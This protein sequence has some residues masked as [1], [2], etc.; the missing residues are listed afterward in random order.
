MEPVTHPRSLSLNVLLSLFCIVALLS[1][2]GGSS[3]TLPPSNVVPSEA[4]RDAASPVAGRILEE[5][6][7]LATLRISVSNPQPRPDAR[8]RHYISLSTKGMTFVFSGPSK[9]KM[10]VSVLTKAPG[11]RK[12]SG[13]TRCVFTLRLK[14][15]NYTGNVSAYD[16]VPVKGKI[17]AS[18]NLLSAAVNVSFKILPNVVNYRRFILDGVVKALSIGAFPSG[19][20]GTVASLAITVTATDADG[21][22]IVGR[23]DN[24]IT[25]SDGDGSGATIVATY[26]ADHPPAHQLLSSIDVATL[27][28]TGGSIVSA[29]IGAS[30]TGATSGNATFTPTPVLTSLS[31]TSGLIGTSVSETLTGNFAAGAT[32]VEVSGTGVTV[33]NVTSTVSAISATFSLDPSAAAGTR[34]VTVST[35]AATSTPKTFAVSNTGVDVVTIGTDSN[36]GMPPG[37][38]SGASGD[39]RHAILHSNAGDRIIFDTTAMCAAAQCTITLAGPLPPI[40]QNLTIDGGSFGRVTIDGANAYRAFWA[41]TGIITIA[42]LQIQ[43]VKAKGGNGGGGSLAAGG[44][45]GAGLGAGLFVDAATVYITN[46]YFLNNAAI[47]G[48]GGVGILGSSTSYVAG[49]GGG[50]MGGDGGTVNSAEGGGGGGGVLGAGSGGGVSAGGN[51]GVGFASTGGTGSVYQT[52]TSLPSDDGG[53]GGYGGGGGGAGGTACTSCAGGGNGGTGGFGAGG[54]GGD[55][56]GS[57]SGGHGGFGGGGGGVSGVVSNGGDGG[58][59]G[60]G[61][62]PGTEGS[63]PS[64]S[65]SAGGALYFT[66]STFLTGGEG[67]EQAGGGGAAAGPAIFVNAGTVTTTNSGASGSTATGGTSANGGPFS[68]GADATPVF[69]YGGTVNGVSVTFPNGGPVA[70]VLSNSPPSLRRRNSRRLE[71]VGTLLSEAPFIPNE[72]VLIRSSRCLTADGRIARPA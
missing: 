55:S 31:T 36:P 72:G 13:V 16:E 58:A 20:I 18:A 21:N 43:N 68:G 27:T 33:S 38:G 15:G 45:G 46:D 67:A 51:G 10:A 59:G 69:N 62:A 54:G 50:G 47:G 25:L 63:P 29:T 40:V 30:A 56:P 24:P 4:T 2:C 23:Y 57:S 17:P 8:E 66:A 39:L 11:C 42:N 70:S 19:Q 64:A 52:S 22:T 7:V 48:N 60:G 9:V 44:G 14:T 5:P 35:S 1:G 37:T 32:N 49:G 3:T 53:P 6:H 28:Y 71:F 12:S 26:G 41:E 34:N 65:S 61:G